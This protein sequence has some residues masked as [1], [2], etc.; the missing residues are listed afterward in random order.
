MSNLLCAAKNGSM[1]SLF[2]FLFAVFFALIE[3]EVE[4]TEGWA[5]NLPTARNI[6]GHLTLYHV[7]MILLAVLII[8]GFVY[9]QHTALCSDC[10]VDE[11]PPKSIWHK[12]VWP[13]LRVTFKAVFHIIAYFLIQDF[14]WFVLN[15]GYTVAKYA[16]THIPWHKPWWGGIPAF[17]FVGIGAMFVLA[18][19]TLFDPALTSST[20]AYILFLCLAVAAAPLYHM[21]YNRIH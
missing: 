5:K 8:T 12:T 15:P 6:I 21:F 1:T 19:L 4:G 11:T 17:N 10:T 3:I 9:F 16:K 18:S 20:F 14:L 13:A 2:V 7:Y